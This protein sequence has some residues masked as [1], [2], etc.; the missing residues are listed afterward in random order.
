[1]GSTVSLTVIVVLAI[2]Q[3]VLGILRAFEGFRIGVKLSGHSVFMLPVLG[4]VVFARGGLVVV[5]ALLYIL[6]ALG[7]LLGQG[8]AGRQGFRHY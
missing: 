5:I 3:G 1:M 6:C 8:W 7:A 4:A 2:M